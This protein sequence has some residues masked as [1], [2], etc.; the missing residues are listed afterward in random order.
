MARCDWVVETPQCDVSTGG[1]SV[2]MGLSWGICFGG[3]CCRDVPVVRLHEEPKIRDK[4]GGMLGQVLVEWEA[5]C[6]FAL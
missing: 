6:I 2:V 4:G 1:R 3:N 5:D